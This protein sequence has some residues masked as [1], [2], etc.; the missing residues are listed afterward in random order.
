MLQISPAAAAHIAN[1]CNARELGDGAGMR[2]APSVSPENQRGLRL[3][4]VPAPE[5]GDQIVE[6]GAARV[7]LARE[8][9]A[10]VSPFVLDT[11]SRPG[12]DGNDRLVLRTGA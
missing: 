3:R 10:E 5:A 8:V 12:A 9:V 6:Q 7:F 1:Q 2:V 4:Y 11:A